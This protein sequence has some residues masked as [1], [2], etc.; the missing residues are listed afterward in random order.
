M[1]I[2]C[3]CTLLMLLY[4]VKAS[5]VLYISQVMCPTHKVNSFLF[6]LNATTK[7]APMMPANRMKAT[8]DTE[9]AEVVTT[10]Q[11]VQK[12]WTIQMN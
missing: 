5:P 8:S 3:M 4:M 6:F 2:I 10:V 9:T 12:I 1:R 7:S 11:T